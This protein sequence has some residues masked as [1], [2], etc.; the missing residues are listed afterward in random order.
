MSRKE[1]NCFSSLNPTVKATI[2]VRNRIYM[3]DITRHFELVMNIRARSP[4]VQGI[5]GQKFQ[6]EDK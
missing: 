2:I 4:K 3:R 5:S 6:L 1:I